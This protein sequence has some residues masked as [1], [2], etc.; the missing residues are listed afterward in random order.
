MNLL[1]NL[2]HIS[3]V[4]LFKYAIKELSKSNKVY[5]SVRNRGNL[6]S[7]VEKEI[8]VPI[9]VV[10][11]HQKY[12]YEKL[13]GIIKGELKYLELIKKLKINISINQSFN[14]IWACKLNGI[15]F[16]TFEDDFEYKIAFYYTKW[17]VDADVMPKYIPVKGKNV[18]NYNGFKELAYLHPSKYKPD[19]SVLNMYDLNPFEY[20]F[21]RE[22][23]SVSLNYKNKNDYLE[24]ILPIFKSKKIK[25]IL[26][27]EDK[28]ILPKLNEKFGEMIVLEEPVEDIFSIIKYAKF[29]VS[30]GDTVARESALLCT[31]C[32]YTGGRK[33]IINEPLIQLGL[34]IEANDMNTIMERID[35]LLIN[36]DYIRTRTKDV[37]SNYDDTT[38]I[39][40]GVIN[41]FVKLEHLPN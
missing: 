1:F 20:V 12:F 23:S 2:V 3:D 7:I 11:Q 28:I 31:P 29:S 35:F 9:Y 16:I 6:L 38:D 27:I 34:I 10:G 30:S 36:H 25:I 21:I 39:I 33:M 41:K 18:I 32:I 8:S 5:V 4:N 24:R 17:F 19:Q 14:N 26:S 15:P 13:I 37:I 22:I 40:L